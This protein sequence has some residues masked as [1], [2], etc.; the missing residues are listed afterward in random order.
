MI[1]IQ[2]Q[3]KLLMLILGGVLLSIIFSLFKIIITLAP[4][5]S[6]YYYSARNLLYEINLYTDQTLF[7]GF[8]YPPVTALLFIP[9]S[10]LPYLLAQ[11]LWVLG[12]FIALFACIA[13]SLRLNNI[14]SVRA[15]VFA[16][17]LAF[18][19]FPTKFTLGMGQ[20]N[21]IALL[22]FLTSL[23]KVKRNNDMIIGILLTV[24]FILKPQLSI[25]LPI[26]FLF[27]KKTAGLM[28]MTFYALASMLTG[29]VFGWESWMTY[30]TDML[31]RLV[32]FQGR[33][34][35]YNQGLSAFFSRLLPLPQAFMAT[36]V[37]SITLVMFACWI[38]ARKKLTFLQSIILWI[39]LYLMIEPLSWQHHYI[40]LLPAYIWA[41]TLTRYTKR[42]IILL[43]LS[44]ILVS[45]NL[46]DPQF[47]MQF[48]YWPFV[49]SHVLWG[50]QVL[51][52]FCLWEGIRSKEGNV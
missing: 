35:Y 38:I 10:I 16:A 36:T 24:S 31:P 13:L 47:W 30:F 29:I 50:T 22:F 12:S 19:S 34:I 41:Y 28:S 11:A 51:F 48:W 9:L 18:L 7:T 3:R 20:S 42:G 15:F 44:Y 27:N 1:Q 43:A 17:I 46:K 40:F 33:E 25:F 8:G 21:I 37:F 45:M 6:V 5:F 52:G 26:F 23:I 4:D 14:F 39:P 2:T 49:G 32:V